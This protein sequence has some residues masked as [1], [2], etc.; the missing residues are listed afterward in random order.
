MARS[1]SPPGTARQDSPTL[2]PL[3]SP[4]K[5]PTRFSTNI[6]PPPTQPLPN[7]PRHGHNG[8]NFDEMMDEFPIPT[9]QRP[10]AITTDEVIGSVSDGSGTLTV[11]DSVEH[12]RTRRPRDFHVPFEPDPTQDIVRHMR[13]QR[14]RQLEAEQQREQLLKEIARL[15]EQLSK[16]HERKRRIAQ[17]QDALAQVE[18]LN[19]KIA[20]YSHE[21]AAFQARQ[22]AV[23]HRQ[24]EL[25]NSIHGSALPQQ[26]PLIPIPPEGSPDK[27]AHQ[28]SPPSYKPSER[29]TGP[30]PS[31][32]PLARSSDSN[33]EKQLRWHHRVGRRVKNTC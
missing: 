11:S 26:R 21:L 9:S 5:R 4:S 6:G 20:W 19:E 31:V 33:K 13:Y 32:S 2:S 24:Q 18:Q 22:N 27:G 8:W 29:I 3:L 17:Q 23:L 12:R 1:S 16:H 14:R 30:D 10:K 7:T 15:R 25:D 28:P